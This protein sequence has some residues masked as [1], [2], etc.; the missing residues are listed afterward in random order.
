MKSRSPVT[1]S[2]KLAKNEIMSNLTSFNIEYTLIFFHM[3]L[4]NI[5][6]L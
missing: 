4:N 6:V 1:T 5:D 3:Q 2:K